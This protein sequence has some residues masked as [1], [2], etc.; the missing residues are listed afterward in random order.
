[1][2]NSKDMSPTGHLIHHSDRGIQYCSSDYINLLVKNEIAI[3]MTENGDALENALAERVNGILKQEYL[4][5]YKITD[6][7]QAKNYLDQAIKLYNSE[8]PHMSIVY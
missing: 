7:Y 6:I 3:S 1:V 5:H 2:K 8:R 4:E